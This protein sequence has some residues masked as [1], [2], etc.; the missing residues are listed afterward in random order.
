MELTSRN[1][2][3]TALMQVLVGVALLWA[4]LMMVGCSSTANYSHAT[5]DNHFE[6]GM[7]ACELGDYERASRHFMTAW[8]SAREIG[9]H[10]VIGDLAF[11]AASS[12][13]ESGQHELAKRMIK[14]ARAEFSQSGSN[15]GVTY[16]LEAKNLKDQE[17]YVDAYSTI[18][19]A[20]TL[21][22]E[23]SDPRLSALEA[24]LLRVDIGLLQK[25]SI[26]VRS[27][28][29]RADTYL[30]SDTSN[31]LLARAAGAFGHVYVLE[32][33]AF[34]AAKQF[35]LE[36]QFLK[37]TSLQQEAAEAWARAGEQYLAAGQAS[38]A[39]ERC[40]IAGEE[41]FELG[42]AL[43]AFTLA[44][45]ALEIQKLNGNTVSIQRVE[46]FRERVS[47][48]LKSSNLD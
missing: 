33:N 26:R 2:V 14:E 29:A 11:L 25:K 18:S 46:N 3:V 15:A 20:V 48:T 35:D 47:G 13:V 28:L 37:Q 34:L 42:D 36:A 44:E 21:L 41:L 38:R 22:E 32:G 4:C 10:G 7:A 39:A 40:I 43:G 30:T 12:A 24:Q 5:I 8:E 31:E 16:Y 17:L 6:Q 1:N 19:Y 27:D 23:E 45:R 9:S